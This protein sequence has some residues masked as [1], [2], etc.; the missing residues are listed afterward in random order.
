ML[1]GMIQVVSGT[2]TTPTGS[3]RTV[4]VVYLPSVATGSTTSQFSMRELILPGHIVGDGGARTHT[5]GRYENS[6]E[7]DTLGTVRIEELP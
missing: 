5:V 6:T 2:P 1:E 3:A 7:G 4:P